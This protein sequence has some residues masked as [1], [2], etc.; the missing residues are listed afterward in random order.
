MRH[1]TPEL[2]HHAGGLSWHTAMCLSAQLDQDTPNL[3]CHFL[4]SY[5]EN[6]LEISYVSQHA[7]AYAKIGLSR[8]T[9]MCRN[10]EIYQDM[11]T[12]LA[13]TCLRTWKTVLGFW[14]ISAHATY[15][16]MGLSRNTTARH[17]TAMDQDTLK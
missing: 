15:A 11:L 12:V 1:E 4:L 7:Q 3:Y 5:M 2:T 10:A 6:C 13:C 14:S 8:H 9:A 17:I 16:E